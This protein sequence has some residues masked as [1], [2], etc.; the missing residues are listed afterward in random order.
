MDLNQQNDLL[1]TLSEEAPFH[2]QDI[3]CFSHKFF[4]PGYFPCWVFLH[5]LSFLIV[6]GGVYHISRKW[7]SKGLKIVLN[8]VLDFINSKPWHLGYLNFFLFVVDSYAKR[9]TPTS[10]WK[11]LTL[12][13]WS[14]SS[15]RVLEGFQKF[16][17][18][19]GLWMAWKTVY[20]QEE[21]TWI[22]LGDKGWVL[23]NEGSRQDFRTGL[24]QVGE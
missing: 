24:C 9:E 11:T 12:I 14:S 5:F 4:P 3:Y 23:G 21:D 7:R 15:C 2:V 1:T 6:F 10:F 18:R 16:E 20:F 17:M 13:A 22:Q 8:S 19:T